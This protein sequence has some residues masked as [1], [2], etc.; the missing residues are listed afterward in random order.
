MAGALDHL[1]TFT[2]PRMCFIV[3][4]PLGVILWFL[5]LTIMVT[6]CG[7]MWNSRSFLEIVKPAVTIRGWVS[8]GSF[9]TGEG[10]TYTNA[11]TGLT[12]PLN[13]TSPQYC[14]KPVTQ[15]IQAPRQW[16]TLI[17]PL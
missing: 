7:S 8:A 10:Q 16:P 17:R 15:V 9:Y 6:I 13:I 2:T 11:T 14:R 3:H 1:M 4:Y 5:R 12:V